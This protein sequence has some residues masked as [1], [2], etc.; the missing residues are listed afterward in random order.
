ME[1]WK[2]HHPKRNKRNY[3]NKGSPLF[4]SDL[5]FLKQKATTKTDTHQFPTKSEFL[6]SNIM[7][8]FPTQDSKT[9]VDS[10]TIRHRLVHTEQLSLCRTKPSVADSTGCGQPGASSAPGSLCYPGQVKSTSFPLVPS[11]G[12]GL[13][14]SKV[15]SDPQLSFQEAIRVSSTKCWLFSWRKHSSLFKQR[16]IY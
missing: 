3:C 10:S 2:H 11:D 7:Q 12:A 15:L 8:C 16:L 4:D 13:R 9:S 5:P 14:I 1:H 6:N